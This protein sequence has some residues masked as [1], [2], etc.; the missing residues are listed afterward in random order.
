MEKH[1]NI[2][3]VCTPDENYMVDTSEKVLAVIKE[4]IL[5]N[6]YFT[7]NRA[8]Q[9]GKTTL[10]DTIRR[11]LQ[12]EY[13][14]V[15]LSFEA[16]SGMFESESKFVNGFIYL[17]SEALTMCGAPEN[18]ID[19]WDVPIKE[20]ADI[21]YL[22]SKITELCKNSDR[23]IILMID[24]A[25]RNSDNQVFLTFLGLLREKYL[26]WKQYKNSL[27]RTFKSVIL[28][29][30]YDIKNMQLRLRSENE[31]RYNSP[32]NIAAD[33][34]IDMSFSV[35]EIATML[36]DYENDHHYGMNVEEFSKRIYEYTSGYPFLVSCL[37]K[38]MD[39][40]VWRS[41]EFADKKEAWSEAGF[42]KAVKRITTQPSTLFDDMNKKLFDN[43]QLK[44]MVR[45]MLIDGVEYVFSTDDD[46]IQLGV[47]FGY[48]E[49]DSGRVCI[50]NRIFEM[51]LYTKFIAESQRDSV[52][53][54]QGDAE[55][56]QFIRDGI[57]NMDLILERFKEH[58]DTYYSVKNTKFLEDNGRFLFLTFLKPII[59]GEGNYYIEARTRDQMRT[60][61]IVDYHG[62][63]Y[64]IEMKIWH[65]NSYQEKG[66]K[67][68]ADYLENYHQ[69]QGWLISFCFNDSKKKVT[70]LQKIEENGKIITEI[71]V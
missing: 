67:Q 21:M 11:R 69:N 19:R 68:L 54:E 53:Y 20:N 35:N 8:R 27:T 48:F 22:G 62:R 55:K 12:E 44:E 58:Y 49:N 57:L 30:V 47:T 38:L 51:R 1:F 52:M 10:L 39:E 25:D 40:E 31:H 64:I 66:R 50:S 29:G 56:N 36:E 16:A 26:K 9:Y 13:Y 65:G 28:A 37:C 63:Q 34:N 42:Q 14:V 46:I 7:I 2:E 33:F 70:G 71:V 3:G 4:Y 32:W 6:K 15:T 43:P 61:I 23:E 60:D 18:L 5:K 17:V 45:K 41:D 24:E 59:N